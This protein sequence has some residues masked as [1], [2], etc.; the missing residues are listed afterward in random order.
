MCL[1]HSTDF[2]NGLSC[3]YEIHMKNSTSGKCSGCLKLLYKLNMHLVIFTYLYLAYEF[4]HTLSFNQVDYERSF[5][6]LKI[7]KSRLCSLI[8]NVNLE[9]FM[10]MCVEKELSKKVNF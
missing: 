2:Y 10:L 6:K 9:A 8:K 1:F 5:S 3:K 7:I 4:I